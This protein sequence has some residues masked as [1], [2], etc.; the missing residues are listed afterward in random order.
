M[1]NYVCLIQFK[2]Q[3]IRNIKDTVKRGDAAMAEAE[4]MGM[5]IVEEFWTMGAYDAVVVLEAPDDETMSAFMLKIASLGNVTSQ[6]LR[7][8]R[9]NEMEQILAKLS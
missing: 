9:R 6:T 3:G 2:D 1:A 7:A 4:K 5:K 8:F